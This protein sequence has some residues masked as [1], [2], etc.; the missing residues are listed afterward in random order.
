MDE[1]TRRPTAQGLAV[2]VVG[3]SI[4]VAGV[5][6]IVGSLAADTFIGD[7]GGVGSTL[8]VTTVV[9]FI[10][11]VAGLAVR[12]VLVR[13]A[14]SSRPGRISVDRGLRDVRSGVSGPHES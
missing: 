12:R 4:G 2:A 14:D 7:R 10:T 13:Q 1:E 11:T 9:V 5:A 8:V 6:L 3:G